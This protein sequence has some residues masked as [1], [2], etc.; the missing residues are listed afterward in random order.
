[1]R[2][3]FRS[4]TWGVAVMAVL[5]VLVSGVALA[6]TRQAS[7]TVATTSGHPVPV[8]LTMQEVRE[9][10]GPDFPVQWDSLKVLDAQGKE[11]P[12]QIDDVDFSGTVSR[13]DELAFVASGP[14]TIQVADEKTA[15]PSYPDLFQATAKP[16]G[17]TVIDSQ[18]GSF[19][20]VVSKEGTL[21]VTRYDKVDS[22]FVK[23]LG[24]L[25]YAGFPMS[26][27]WADKNLG[28]HQE[29]TTLEEPLRVVKLAVLP[30]SPARATVVAN[31]ASDLFPGMRETIIA[32]IYPTGEI[33]VEN[34]VT[35]YGY[36]DFT[37]LETMATRVLAGAADAV[38]IL[39]VFRYLDWASELGITPS[40]YWKAQGVLQTLNGRDY[41]VFANTLGPKPPWWGASYIFASPERWR[42]NYS[43]SMKTGVAELLLNVPDVPADASLADSIKAEQWQLE[44]DEWRTGYFRWIA[45][46][47]I[48]IR[49]KNN[50]AVPEGFTSDM[51]AGDWPLHMIPGDTFQV[52]N[53]YVLYHATDK[54]AAI[55]Y[56]E[57]RY[58]DLS[59]VQIQPQ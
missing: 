59:S 7:V 23:D 31:L 57:N 55:Q 14:V 3:L 4:I 43:A 18:D 37:K 5:I 51:S 40:Q 52:Q 41:V 46:E 26:T 54:N 13:Y 15:K 9:A 27:Y 44:G 28:Q 33:R 25:R 36:S 56:L 20:V 1:M 32:G 53:Y 16:D 38:H 50:I 30:H 58:Q 48:M 47:M 42:T 35:T 10:I 2:S 29:K 24:M 39:P 21:S 34:T 11:I 19:Q 22:A 12:Y 6:E 45:D 49:K 8:S 17:T